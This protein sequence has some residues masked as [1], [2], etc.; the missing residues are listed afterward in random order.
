MTEDKKKAAEVSKKEE[1][2][3]AKE[4]REDAEVKQ[5]KET[6]YATLSKI[7]VKPYIKKKMGLDYLSWATAWGLV[8]AHY[9][10]AKKEFTE[11][12]E[13]IPTK[14]G[15][16][17][18]GR[19]VPYRLTPFG[20]EV[21]ATVTING[22]KT[23]QNLYVMNNKGEAVKANGLDMKLINKAQQRCL[24]KALATAGLGLDIYAGEDLPEEPAKKTPQRVSSAPS[25]QYR[26]P[27]KL[28]KTQLENYTVQ[29]SDGKKYTLKA[30]F[31]RAKTNDVIKQWIKAG[32]YDNTTKFYI[33]QLGGIYKAEQKIKDKSN[34]QPVSEDDGFEDIIAK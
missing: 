31:E 2:T 16:T 7:D 18:T 11:Y 14:E 21:E 5:Q 15:W 29:F 22:E 23:S 13:F 4:A 12:P 17:P 32:N 25:R 30:I 34:Q 27:R 28:S 9:P 19:D 20:C 1:K 33:K 10:D 26:Q 8:K 24:V 6:V 3:E